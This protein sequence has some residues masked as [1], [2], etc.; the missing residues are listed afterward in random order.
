MGFRLVPSVDVT[1]SPAT[2]AILLYNVTN[3]SATR[4]KIRFR[5][6]IRDF[7]LFRPVLKIFPDMIS[8]SKQQRSSIGHFF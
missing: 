5:L 4:F 2:T 6:F 7:Y 3:N 8:Q 1:V